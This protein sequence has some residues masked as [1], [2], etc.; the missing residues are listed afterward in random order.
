MDG[1]TNFAIW[2]LI[3]LMVIIGM[4]AAVERQGKDLKETSYG[5]SVT[6]GI[7]G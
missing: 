5:V 6:L 4:A 3:V 7:R 2:G 1:I